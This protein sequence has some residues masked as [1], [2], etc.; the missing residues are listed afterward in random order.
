M[1]QQ[2]IDVFGFRSG[3]AL[4]HVTKIEPVPLRRTPRGE[5]RYPYMVAPVCP[6]FLL[7]LVSRRGFQPYIRTLCEAEDGFCP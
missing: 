1:R 7:L 5:K 2:R 4:E 6:G 3:Q